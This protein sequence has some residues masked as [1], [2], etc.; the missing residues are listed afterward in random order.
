M[1]INQH[2]AAH[3]NKRMSAQH[4]LQRTSSAA[5][6]SGEASLLVL[7]L[8]GASASTASAA[9]A[10]GPGSAARERRCRSGGTCVSRSPR[11]PPASVRHGDS[12]FSE[13]YTDG[14]CR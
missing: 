3:F 14:W 10:S 5:S 11:N 2:R 12:T 4:L 13:R 7:R 6:A 1:A 8:D 9:S